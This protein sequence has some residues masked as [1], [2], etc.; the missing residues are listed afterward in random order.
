M[1]KYLPVSF[2]HGNESRLGQVFLNLLINAAQ[3]IPEGPAAEHAVTAAVRDGEPGWVIVEVSDTGGGIAPENLSRIFEPFFTTKPV[4]EGTGLGL[5]V[6]HGIVAGMGGKIEVDSKLGQGTTF[7]IRLPA[8]SRAPRD[9]PALSPLAQR[10]LTPRRVLVIDDD[11]EVRLALARIVGSPHRIELA[12]TAREAQQR[13]LI[14]RED[15]DVIFC[16]LMMPDLTGMDLYES[17]SMQRPE[18]LTRMVFMSAGAFTPRATAFLERVN[19]RRIDKPF[20]PLKVR[21]LLE[22]A[23]RA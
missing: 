4:V 8:A 22:Q 2:V 23:I 18:I 16:D 1:R 17:V 11:P 20:D 21:A 9:I 13:L 7:R 19:V 14:R 3:A 10:S 6:C 15:Y 12:E 5:S